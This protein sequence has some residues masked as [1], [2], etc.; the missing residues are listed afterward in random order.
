M[1]S[2]LSKITISDNA[3]IWERLKAQL[4]AMGMKP[5]TDPGLSL[6]LIKEIREEVRQAA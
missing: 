6:R 5:E 1:A 4:S 2:V 3:L